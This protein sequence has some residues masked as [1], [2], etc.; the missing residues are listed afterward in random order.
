MINLAS[1]SPLSP[2][3]HLLVVCHGSRSRRWVA[4]L[5]EWY[6]DFAR[7]IDIPSE[8][9]FLEI[10]EPSFEERLKVWRETNPPGRRCL[11]VFPF[12]LSESGHAGDEIPE[13]VTDILGPRE[14]WLLVRPADWA[15]ALAANSARRLLASGARPGDEIIVCGYGASKHDDK[16]CE[17]VEAVSRE[18][19]PFHDGPQWRWA[20]CGHFLE[21]YG[22][23]LRDH[24][25]EIAAA[26]AHARVAILPL[27]LAVSSYQEELIPGVLREFPGLD[28]RFTPDSILP[29]PDISRW[30]AE[31]IRTSLR[32]ASR[33]RGG[34]G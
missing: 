12:F 28:V 4:A 3:P 32:P 18:A 6:R 24:L 14:G 27:F 13:L 17:L 15:G 8:L 7:Q 2:P 26:N 29:D 33:S 21:D 10:T 20:P 23:P 5:Q 16:W 34:M 1:P 19:D 25:A 30:A 9:T 11:A 22:A 31:A